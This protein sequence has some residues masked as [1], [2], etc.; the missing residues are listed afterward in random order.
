[1]SISADIEGTSLDPKNQHRSSAQ[2][3]GRDGAA[4]QAKESSSCTCGHV[5]SAHVYTE[6]VGHAGPCVLQSCK[7][8]AF[9]RKASDVLPVQHDE[10]RTTQDD[11]R[12]QAQTPGGGVVERRGHAGD[13][14]HPISNLLRAQA[15]APVATKDTNPKDAAAGLP[16]D[17]AGRKACPV[18]SGVLAYF[19]DAIAEVARLSKVGND[20]HNPGEPLHWAKEKSTD[21]DDCISRHQMDRAKGEV[22]IAE[23]GLEKRIRHRAAVAWRALAALQIEIEAESKA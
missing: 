21:H 12:E 3:T 16:E 19:P 15:A 11:L 22:F 14:D 9:S 2:A 7:C 1:M 13:Y 6:G 23:Y 8:G 4:T 20:K 5:Q 17:S 18:F 10:R